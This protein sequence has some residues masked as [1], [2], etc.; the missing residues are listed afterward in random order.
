[1]KRVLAVGIL[2]TITWVLAATAAP[3]SGSWSFSVQSNLNPFSFTAIESDLETNYSVGGW[4]FSSTVLANLA[5][6]DN[7]FFDAKG[8]LGGFALRSI[9]DFDAA[10][11][12]FQAWLAS[13]VTAIGGVNLY[14]LFMLDN[15]GSAQTPSMGSGLTL[16]GWA[17]VGDLSF[18][19]QTR[20][21]MNNTS[22][23]VYRYGYDWLLDHFIFKVCN[24][25]QKPSG[26][27]SVQTGGCT[28][29]W[30]GA[31]VH[32]EMPFSCFN[33]LT[34]L[35]VSCTGFNYALF[36][37]NDIDL[38]LSWLNLKW[39]DVTFTTN[40]KS[41]NTVFDI[42]VG[43]TA[44]ITPYFALESTGT[45]IAQ[46]TGFSLKALK[47]SYTWDNVTF[48]AGHIFGNDGWYP[49]LNYTTT[50]YYG[51]TWDGELST[52]PNCTVPKNYDE[53]FGLQATGDSCCGGS[54]TF[55]AFAWFDTG[56]SLG[57]FDWVET[58][59]KLSVMVGSNTT[60]NFG[61][62]VPQTGSSWF[63]FGVDV[64]W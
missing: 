55:S 44:C 14:A 22:D 43:K 51:W 18:W 15:V 64:T 31:D 25:W 9:L 61:M 13:G 28:A 60:F 21:N 50:K 56:N 57:L 20:F 39:V 8:T 2:V 63:R 53:Y 52:L 49:Y 33:L 59:A 4:T 10:P 19:G 58:R 46:I 29:N 23:Y 30:S 12:Q 48:K 26:Y 62:S 5:G 37:I 36:E 16:G 1:M 38:G 41:V 40:S 7:V 32:V 17:K 11:A 27:I 24:T 45:Q 42:N 34:H 6:L 3:L 47:F 35:S 54:F